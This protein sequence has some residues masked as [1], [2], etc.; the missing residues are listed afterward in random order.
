MAVPTMGSTRSG[1]SVRSGWRAQVGLLAL[2]LIPV[3]TGTARLVEVFGGPRT[4]PDN[5]RIAGAASPAVLH[6]VGGAVFLVLGALQFSPRL[7]QRHP[8]WHRRAGR[9]LMLLGVTAALA[10]LWMTLLYPRQTGTGSVLHALR[11]GFGTA[12]AATIFLG[13]RAIKR[14]DLVQ[15]RAWMTR[16]YAIALAAGTQALTIGV[17]GAMFG[18]TVM[19]TDLS[20]L[21]GWV[22]NLALAE[23]IIRRR[24]AHSP[25]SSGGRLRGG[26]GSSTTSLQPSREDQRAP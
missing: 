17:G 7:R 15:H 1:R 20:T 13:F 8:T 21:A 11:L 9:A 19:V 25:A 24:G 4:M 23:A 10:A 26:L 22:I 6:I 5:P 18:K 14:R 2:A 3:L 12:L 16:A